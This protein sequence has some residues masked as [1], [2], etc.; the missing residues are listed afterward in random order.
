MPAIDMAYPR[1]FRTYERISIGEDGQVKEQ[2]IDAGIKCNNPTKQVMEEA[3]LLFGDDRPVGAL[4]SIGTGH[5]GTIGLLE[6]DGFQKILPTKLIYV[7][8]KTATDCETTAN[9]LARRFENIPEMYFRF[10]VTRGVG[11]ISLEEWKRMGDVQTHTAAYL[12]EPLVS[13]SIDSVVKLLC[14]KSP[15]N[16]RNRYVT[17]TDI[18]GTIKTATLAVHPKP[19]RRTTPCSSPNFTGRRSYLEK[20]QD[21]FGPQANLPQRR[22]VFLLYGMGGAGKTQICLKFAEETSDLFWKTF[23]IDATSSETIGQSLQ[24][25]AD[26]PVARAFG[27]EKSAQSVLRWFSAMDRD[28]LLVFDNADGDPDMVSEFLPPSNRGSI[29]ITSRNPNMRRNVSPKAWVE[30]DRM[31]ENDAISLLLKAAYLDESLDELRLEA[32]LVVAELGFLALAIDQAGA[33]I[34]SGICGLGEYLQMYA[35]HRREL[36]SH[37]PY[38]G[39]SGYGRTAYGPWDMSFE[40][41]EMTASRLSDPVE[42]GSA[43]NAVTIFQIFAIFVRIGNVVN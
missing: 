15:H 18:C 26:D 32:K 39:D 37:P 2:L 7:L 13:K 24:D 12:Q 1:C 3:R 38:K 16:P 20:L 30:V 4:V 22:R 33:A 40:A 29:L 31:E 6:P 35:K 5:P 41:I 36:L 34:G 42:A 11:V 25:I 8:K 23:W 10:N 27:A 21:F 43:R 28:W 17:L 19:L 9:D 14:G